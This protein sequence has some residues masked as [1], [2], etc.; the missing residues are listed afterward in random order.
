MAHVD[1]RIEHP[2]VPIGKRALQERALAHL[3][4]PGDHDHLE[5]HDHPPERLSQNSRLV[6]MPEM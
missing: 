3:P 5:P 1:H 2:H 6:F 4:C